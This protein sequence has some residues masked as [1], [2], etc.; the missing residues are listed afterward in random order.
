MNVKNE[1]RMIKYE[2]SVY[3]FN[4]QIIQITKC[5]YI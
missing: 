3:F 4:I 5:E 1:L 2:I